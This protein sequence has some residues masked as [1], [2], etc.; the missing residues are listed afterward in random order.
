VWLATNAEVCAVAPSPK[1]Q[2]TVLPYGAP[3]ENVTAV[4]AV[5]LLGTV[6]LSVG[7]AVDAGGVVRTGGVV[8]T[9]GAAAPCTVTELLR[10]AAVTVTIALFAELTTAVALP[11]VSVV[12]CTGATVPVL[13]AKVIVTFGTKWPSCVSTVAM[14]FV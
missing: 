2:V 14:T 10:P 7:G 9:D 12:A 6:M 11:L 1:F 4:P 5:P 13:V 8:T 3:T